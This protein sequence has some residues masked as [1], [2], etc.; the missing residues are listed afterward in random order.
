MCVCARVHTTSALPPPR[1]P[2]SCPVPASTPRPAYKAGKPTISHLKHG[3]ELHALSARRG[4]LCN[5]REST[6]LMVDEG[7]LCVCFRL[8]LRRCA[9]AMHVLVW[10]D[11]HVRRYCVYVCTKPPA[12]S[13]RIDAAAPVERTPFCVFEAPPPPR[14][15][16][17]A[18][19]GWVGFNSFFECFCSTVISLWPQ[20]RRGGGSGEKRERQEK[21]LRR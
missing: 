2:L 12:L 15:A 5:M 8:R 11:V 6:V 3:G 4:Q 14:F 7:L 9:I 1:P 18:A 13:D 19:E 17:L 20:R 21:C 16:E 10:V